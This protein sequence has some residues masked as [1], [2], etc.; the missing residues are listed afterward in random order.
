[1]PLVEAKVN[2]DQTLLTSILAI[3]QNEI[4]RLKIKHY[5]NSKPCK[6]GRLAAAGWWNNKFFSIHPPPD[7]INPDM[8]LIFKYSDDMEIIF[9]R[10]FG[11]RHG[12]RPRILER[13]EERDF[14]EN[15]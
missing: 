8:R 12:E 9:V 14:F 7:G 3:F 2:H 15:S 6:K 10:G 4:Y 1:V 11:F 5:A 13:A